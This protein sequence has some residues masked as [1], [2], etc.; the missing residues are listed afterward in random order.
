VVTGRVASIRVTSRAWRSEGGR[1]VALSQWVEAADVTSP[2]AT[3]RDRAESYSGVAIVKLSLIEAQAVR[4]R[5]LGRQAYELEQ[6][7]VAG[8]ELFDHA[9]V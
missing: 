1:G 5:I 6:A 3:V 9:I 7:P 8:I 4:I 2:G